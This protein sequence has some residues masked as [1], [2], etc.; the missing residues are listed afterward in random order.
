RTEDWF[1]LLYENGGF[2]AVGAQG[3]ISASFIWLVRNSGTTAHLYSVAR[4]ASNFVAVGPGVILYSSDGSNWAHAVFPLDSAISALSLAYGSGQFVASGPTGF[5]LRSPDGVHWSKSA[6]GA[7]NAVF[8]LAYG[9]GR[10]VAMVPYTILPL[11][12][13]M[14]ALISTNGEAW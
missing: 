12:L 14:K 7:T 9:N 11:G 4:G 8:S 10:F 5:V 1:S 3:T 13:G 6:I 2:L